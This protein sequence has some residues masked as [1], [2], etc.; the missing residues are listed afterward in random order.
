VKRLRKILKKLLE[1]PGARHAL[2]GL[3][4]ATGMI[5]ATLAHASGGHGGGEAHINWWTWS[6]EAP[7]V[8]WFLVDFVL[9]VWLIVHFA[10]KPVRE[11][12][13]A[14]HDRIKKAIEE[15]A[16][17]HRGASA[18]YQE[19]QGKLANVE[20]EA[21]QFVATGRREGELEKTQ[22]V[23]AARDYA[24]HLKSDSKAVID[25][26]LDRAEKRL[27]RQVATEV[28]ASAKERLAGGL[29]QEEHNR[30]ID[31]AIAELEQGAVTTSTTHRGRA[32]AERPVAGGEA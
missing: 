31:E 22:L 1:R 9:F 17:A 10:K 32:K 28:L 4:F 18:R 2:G 29:A 25:Q 19:Y 6:S 13:A 7:P 15:A 30:L 11:A 14:R 12:F 24:D 21:A 3:G 27:R 26:E 20:Q 16:S 5:L 8:G 23:L